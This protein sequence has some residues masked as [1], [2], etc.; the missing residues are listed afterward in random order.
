[1]LKTTCSYGRDC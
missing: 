1:M